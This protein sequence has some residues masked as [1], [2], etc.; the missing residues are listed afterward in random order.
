MLNH[1]ESRINGFNGHQYE[2]ELPPEVFAEF[3]GATK[4]AREPRYI[5][6]EAPPPPPIYR[7]PVVIPPQPAKS[8]MPWVLCAI[9]ITL[10]GMVT[11]HQPSATSSSTQPQVM[12][13]QPVATPTPLQNGPG[14]RYEA[15]APAYD[16]QHV[17]GSQQMTTMPDGSRLITT[18]RGYLGN[19]DELP[20]RGGQ[21]G[22]MWGLWTA[23][24][25]TFWV[26]TTVPNSHRIGWVDPPGD[27]T[28]VRRA[29]PADNVE[30]RRAKMVVPRAEL[31]QL[32]R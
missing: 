27:G 15:I 14:H 23:G 1:P 22:D 19:V 28:E 8:V 6:Q 9:L 5:P 25:P 24:G 12:R 3:V 16:P 31:V 26:L 18:F 10:L 7:P 21:L 30:V 32:S 17:I 11:Q 20:L 4:V 29:L 2:A 13:A